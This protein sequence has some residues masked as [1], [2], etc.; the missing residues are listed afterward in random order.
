MK[1]ILR[2]FQLYT[3]VLICNSQLPFLR[4]IMTGPNVL[5]PIMFERNLKIKKTKKMVIIGNLT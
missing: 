3:I 2:E 1:K 5:P 4:I